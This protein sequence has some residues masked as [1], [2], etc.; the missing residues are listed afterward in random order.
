MHSQPHARQTGLTVVATVSGILRAEIL[1]S[2][3]EQAGIAVMLGYESAGLLFGITASGL[4]LSQVRLLV[5]DADA[6]EAKA[7]LDTPPPPGWEEQDLPT[8]PSP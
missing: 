8:P 2:K 4:P 6:I 1:K 3:L 7:I 5:A